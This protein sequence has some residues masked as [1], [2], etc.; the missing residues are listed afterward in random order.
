MS[1]AGFTLDAASIRR[2]GRAIGRVEQMRETDRVW[3]D[4]THRFCWVQSATMFAPNRWQYELVPYDD[5]SQVIEARNW[6]ERDNTASWAAPGYDLSSLPGTFQMLPVGEDKNAI[7]G[8]C[9]V[10]AR[11]RKLDGWLGWWFTAPNPIDGDCDGGGL[12]GPVNLEADVTGRLTFANFVDA[13]GAGL[14]GASGAGDYGAIGVGL[15]LALSGGTLSSSSVFASSIAGSAITGSTAEQQVVA[16]TVPA[17]L[18][19]VVG[20]VFRVECDMLAT[21]TSTHTRT[22]RIYWWDGTTETQIGTAVALTGSNATWLNR[23][24]ATIVTQATGATGRITGASVVRMGTGATFR[25]AAALTTAT[26]NTH[27][28][29][30]AGEIR[31]KTQSNNSGASVTMLGGSA[32]V[33]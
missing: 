13:P 1:R 19:N 16:F 23:L 14:V 10:E 7:T 27:D 20:R 21:F 15:N 8:E 31:I 30:A 32:R 28:L 3:P 5:Q 29:T 6:F 12:G 11:F 17:G 33:D 25:S 18:A 2:I 22:T 24:T 4:G 9:G 26:G